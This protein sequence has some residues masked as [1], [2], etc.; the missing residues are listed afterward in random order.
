MVNKK[1]LMIA[2]A[3]L[4]MAAGFNILRIGIHSAFN[5]HSLVWLWFIPVFTAFFIMFNRII[6][7]NNFRIKSMDSAKA[8]LYKFLTL[9]G[10]LIIIFMMTLG[11]TLRHI[12]AVPEAF[13][14]F[15]YTGLG[16]ALFTAGA[17]SLV[18]VS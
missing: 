18:S 2:N 3:L 4:W 14:A 5:V 9:K 13:F 15:F 7:K 10:Y 12:G 1:W 11:I 6:Q 17:K 16:G 8:P